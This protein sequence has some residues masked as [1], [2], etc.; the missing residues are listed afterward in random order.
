MASFLDTFLKIVLLSTQIYAVYVL[1]ELLQKMK[2]ES[3]ANERDFT[4]H[5]GEHTDW[6]IETGHPA[7]WITGRLERF[8]PA[9]RKAQR[10]KQ[11]W[12][13]IGG[14]FLFIIL[15]LVQLLA[16]VGYFSVDFVPG[17]R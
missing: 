9:F 7:E 14:N 6:M 10:S 4:K 3:A 16:C 5:Y 11:F 1:G 17:L 12:N 15:V 8:K 2:I 13:G